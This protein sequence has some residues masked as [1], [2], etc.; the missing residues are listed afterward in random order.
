MLGAI[1]NENPNLFIVGAPRK[2][3]TTFLYHYLK[4]HP[5][6]YFPDFK[7]PHF[8]GSDLNRRNGA[9]NLSLSEYK[10]L[11]KTDKK[12]IGEASTFYLFQKKL[13]KNYIILTHSLKL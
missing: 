2:C 3:G 10:S 13:Q 6:I 4:K 1:N 7:E 9:Y 8:F 5:D 11:F 12:V